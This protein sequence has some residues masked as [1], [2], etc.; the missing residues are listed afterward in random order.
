MKGVSM[1]FVLLLVAGTLDDVVH[2]TVLRKQC[3]I[4][5]VM[6]DLNEKL[7]MPSALREQIASVGT[8]VS[9]SK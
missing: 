2:N 3:N 6:G 5:E 4:Q 7:T 9:E 1:Y 8:L